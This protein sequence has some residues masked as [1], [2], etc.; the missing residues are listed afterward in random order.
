GVWTVLFDNSAPPSRGFRFFTVLAA[1]LLLGAFVFLRQYF[2]DQALVALLQE[3]RRGYES[4][5][6]LQ[7]QLVQKEKLASL[8][9]LVA[10]AASEIDHPLAAV[11]SYSEQLWAQ[12]QL[13]SEQNKLL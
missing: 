10:G 9:N 7:T 8:G 2:Q 12:E 6:R 4:Q 13:S 3:S 1:M 5:K 11:M